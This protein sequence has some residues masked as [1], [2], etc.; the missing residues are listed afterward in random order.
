MIQ[1]LSSFRNNK[2]ISS[3]V[4]QTLWPVPEKVIKKAMAGMKKVVVPDMNMGQYLVEIER[5]ARPEIEVIGI[6]KMNTM[7][8]SPTEIIEKGGLL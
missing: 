6:D 7:L 5:L 1:K 2:K 3:L 4:L 8:L